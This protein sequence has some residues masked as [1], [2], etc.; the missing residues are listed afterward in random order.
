MVVGWSGDGPA[1][2]DLRHVGVADQ[3]LR[4]AGIH[5]ACAPRVVSWPK[6]A[7]TSM[8]ESAAAVNHDPINTQARSTPGAERR[9]E[10]G[11]VVPLVRGEI[12]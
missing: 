11:F 2:A 12:D 10:P 8:A 5:G 3:K 1:K 9:A 7:I 6:V 4:K